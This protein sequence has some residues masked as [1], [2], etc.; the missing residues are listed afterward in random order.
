MSIAE[1]SEVLGKVAT[2]LPPEDMAIALFNRNKALGSTIL[3]EVIRSQI[4]T[5]SGYDAYLKLVKRT[6]EDLN[7]DDVIDAII[8]FL[9]EYYPNLIIQISESEGESKLALEVL[10]GIL[11]VVRSA[12]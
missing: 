4:T 11:Q 8:Y 12:D 9:D 2:D 7:D 3:T 10:G 5:I 1:F 6:I